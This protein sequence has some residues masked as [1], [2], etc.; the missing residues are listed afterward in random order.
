MNKLCKLYAAG[1][2]ALA[3]TIPG[4]AAAATLQGWIRDYS[5]DTVSVNG[6]HLYIRNSGQYEFDVLSR[7]VLRGNGPGGR[8]G[9][10]SYI[11]LFEH[12]NPGGGSNHL[13]DQ[14]AYDDD[15]YSAGYG[16]GSISNRDSYLTTYLSRGWYVLTI[17]DYHFSETEA[18]RDVNYDSGFPGSYA[19]YRVTVSEIPVPAAAPLLLAGLGG[20]AW[21]RRRQKKA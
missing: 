16:D 7:G 19:E 21:M 9:L 10:D 15:G 20:F 12:Q 2:L 5:N 3:V 11:R 8:S 14:V 4:A 1:A 6:H 18:R 13:G 17:S